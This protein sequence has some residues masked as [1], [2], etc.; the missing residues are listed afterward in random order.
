MLCCLGMYMKDRGQIV[1]FV[2]LS[3]SVWILGIKLSF[4]TCVAGQ[5]SMLVVFQNCLHSIET[6][7]SLSLKLTSLTRFGDLVLF[8]SSQ[9]FT[10]VLGP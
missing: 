7:L 3:T 9:F 5:R 4:Q 8:F 2:A 6:G 1:G 10:W